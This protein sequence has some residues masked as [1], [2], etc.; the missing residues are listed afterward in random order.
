MDKIEEDIL[1]KTHPDKIDREESYFMYALVN[2]KTLVI[3]SLR[4]KK[5]L[6]EMLEKMSQDDINKFIQ[7]SI[8]TYPYGNKTNKLY[9][10]VNNFNM[11]G[12]QLPHQFDRLKLLQ[13]MQETCPALIN[14]ISDARKSYKKT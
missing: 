10:P 3:D 9:K 6:N 11:Y 2:A 14:K 13:S 12:M 7:T 1:S 4:K 8:I 5:E